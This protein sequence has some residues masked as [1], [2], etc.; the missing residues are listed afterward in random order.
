[1]MLR[2]DLLQWPPVTPVDGFS[3]ASSHLS[4][5]DLYIA[6]SNLVRFLKDVSF[7]TKFTSL[8]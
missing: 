2:A 8:Q 1:M 5:Q 4:L 3:A 7:H 6:S